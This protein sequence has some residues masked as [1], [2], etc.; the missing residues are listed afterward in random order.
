VTLPLR[1][2]D[3]RVAYGA[4]SA[5]NGVTVEL[6]VGAVRAVF[7][8]NG[9]GKTS[10][11]RGI[12]GI[13]PRLQGEILLGERRLDRLP[14][15]KI[16][17]AGLIQVPEGRHIVGPL[18]V[19]E[20]LFLGAYAVHD[21]KPE[22]STFGTVESIYELFPVLHARRK[23]PAHSL[24]GGEQQMLALGRALMG[25]PH[26]VL[27]DEPSTGLAPKV[28]DLVFECVEQIAAAGIG[29][30]MV[31]Q[32]LAALDVASYA[33]VLE[34]GKIILEGSS[35]DVAFDPRVAAAYMGIAAPESSVHQ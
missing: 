13:A 26:V 6:P 21:R 22:S 14:A 7:G 31:E 2:S 35:S 18:S 16:A 11:L 29:V 34:H 5:I 30:L 25:C 20:N 8:P 24:S 9:A 4:V 23:L 28:V 33:Y 1:V 15:Y 3:I 17:R 19:E 32:N 12:S 27:L 10:L